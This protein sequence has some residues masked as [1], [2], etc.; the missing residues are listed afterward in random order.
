MPIDMIIFLCRWSRYFFFFSFVRFE[1]ISVL[2]HGVRIILCLWRLQA[3]TN[4]YVNMQTHNK[5]EQ[6]KRN[7]SQWRV[8]EKGT[9]KN[10]DRKHSKTDSR[11]RN[12]NTNYI[13]LNK[14]IEFSVLIRELLFYVRI[15]IY[16]CINMCGCDD[17]K[18]NKRR[19]NKRKHNTDT[20]CWYREREPQW[21]LNWILIGMFLSN[22]DVDPS[23]GIPII[24]AKPKQ[25]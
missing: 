17:E 2:E 1:S 12:S 20:G 15:Y 18:K 10:S 5:F 25:I 19:N 16:I 9:K 22:S 3:L 8:R 23:T 14:F 4:I 6:F 11:A 7:N 13:N 21:N 24:C